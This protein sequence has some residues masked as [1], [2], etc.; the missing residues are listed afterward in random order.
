MGEEVAGQEAGKARA[1]GANCTQARGSSQ[2]STLLPLRRSSVSGGNDA[3]PSLC[4]V[5]LFLLSLSISSAYDADSKDSTYFLLPTPKVVLYFDP[6]LFTHSN[7]HPNLCVPH[8]GLL[9][10]DSASRMGRNARIINC[11]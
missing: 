4:R 5:L 8:H 11:N 9:F 1:V 3:E 6:F 7:A 10:Q 2:T